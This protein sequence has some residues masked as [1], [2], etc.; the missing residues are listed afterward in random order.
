MTREREQEVDRYVLKHKTYRLESWLGMARIFGLLAF[1]M[2][3]LA[4]TVHSHSFWVILSL[5][6]FCIGYYILATVRYIVEWHRIAKGFPVASL[7]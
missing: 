5:F 7:E 3:I 2:F 6:L 1:A 4:H